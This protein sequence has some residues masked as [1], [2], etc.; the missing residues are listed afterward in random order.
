[1]CSVQFTFIYSSTQ[2]VE[3]CSA[4]VRPCLRRDRG[5]GFAIAELV[6]KVVAVLADQDGVKFTIAGAVRLL[7]WSEVEEIA[8]L[9]HPPL[10]TGSFTHR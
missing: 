9:A 7:R 5:N 1:M 10:A 8:V 6:Q 2:P 3:H 4:P